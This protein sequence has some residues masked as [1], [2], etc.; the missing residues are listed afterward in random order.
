MKWLQ[1]LKFLWT[2]RVDLLESV[3]IDVAQSHIQSQGRINFIT[4]IGQIHS[5]IDETT[6]K[7]G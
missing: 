4:K 6:A 2:E 1:Y 5:Y 7:N 3:N